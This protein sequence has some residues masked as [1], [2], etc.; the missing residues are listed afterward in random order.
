MRCLGL[1]CQ[2]GW[3]G[4]GWV[5]RVVGAKPTKD[6]LARGGKHDNGS[7][8]NRS[9]GRSIGQ[10]LFRGCYSVSLF[11]SLS[12]INFLQQLPFK[13]WIVACGV[14]LDWIGLG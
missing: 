9:V 5:D 2:A 10:R 4:L 11:L 12:N 6:I 3:I 14:G 1:N 8:V 7:T 13:D